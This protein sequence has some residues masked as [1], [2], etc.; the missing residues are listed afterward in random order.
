M[1]AYYCD[2]VH[3]ACYYFNGSLLSLFYTLALLVYPIFF[4]LTI[5][6]SK[7]ILE[8]LDKYLFTL[9]KKKYFVKNLDVTHMLCRGRED[10]TMIQ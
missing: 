10:A 8:R 9:A 2:G 7:V 3:L 6:N 5:D 4:Y 1:P